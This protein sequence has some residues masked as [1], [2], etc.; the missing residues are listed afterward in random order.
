MVAIIATHEGI[1]DYR[2]PSLQHVHYIDIKMEL[3]FIGE[4]LTLQLKSRL[5][6]IWWETLS[7]K[8]SPEKHHDK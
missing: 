6:F 1:F 2:C 5:C 3:T 8:F 7:N 4:T